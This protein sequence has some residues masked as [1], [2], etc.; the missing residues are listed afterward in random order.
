ME[1]NMG[2]F[3][4]LLREKFNNNQAEMAK[5]LNISRYQLNMILNHNGKNAGKKVIGAVIKYCDSNNYNFKDY[6][7]LT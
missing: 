5:A 6:I 2:A 1:I 7:F 3:N 4:T